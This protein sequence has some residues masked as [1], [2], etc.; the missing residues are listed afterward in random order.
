M[1]TTRTHKLLYALIAAALALVLAAPA[2]ARM[3]SQKISR[4]VCL[5]TGGGKFVAIPGFPGERIDKR[6]L[7]DVK[8]LQK[9]YKIF[10]TDGFSDDPIHASNGEHPI[11]LALDIVPNAAAGGTW[12]DIDALASFAEPSQDHPVSPFRW[13]GYDGDAGHGRGHH[14]HLSW[15]HSE[16]KPGV[17][18]GSVYTMRCP[19]AKPRRSGGGGG[20]RGGKPDNG[21][22]PS[23]GKGGQAG[24]PSGGGKGG[25]GG[26][27]DNGSSGG[28]TPGK[29]DTGSGGG[30]SSGGLGLGR[31]EA[32]LGFEAGEPVVETG[33]VD[34]GD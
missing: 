6:L 3:T 16:T 29:G 19:N 26:G 2:E 13:V 15:D 17:P 20:G 31:I 34:L 10:V 11:G 4:N 7:A 23:G 14:L 28:L 33:G 32:A 5:T 9:R 24:N 25:G 21:G 30:S 27:N 8:Y 1:T 22:K 18:A 12:R